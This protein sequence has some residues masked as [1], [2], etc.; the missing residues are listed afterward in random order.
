MMGTSG[1]RLP[2]TTISTQRP[3]FTSSSTLSSMIMLCAYIPISPCRQVLE[4]AAGVSGSGDSSS[5]FNL[6]AVQ[7]RWELLY[8]R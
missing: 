4:E 2:R 7:G 8:S 6:F 1:R 5:N 3:S